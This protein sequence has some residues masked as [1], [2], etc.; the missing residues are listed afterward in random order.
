MKIRGVVLHARR[1]FVKEHFGEEAWQ[2]VLDA[3]PTEDQELLRGIVL[4]AQW[5]PFKLGER[6]D[7]AIVD[8]LGGG[9]VKV[10]EK[11][12]A[13]SAQRNLSKEHKS[14]LS[15]GDPQA[16]MKKTQLIYKFYYDS[17]YREYEETGSNSGVITTYEAETFSAPD[18]LTVIGWYKEALRMCGARDVEIV[19][20][21]CRA[22][23]GSCC[24]YRVTWEI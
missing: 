13:K 3:L 14:F 4:S 12:G 21:E 20:E 22:K 17:G 10:F 8:V 15:P 16:F 23:G 9:D 5:Y 19:E 18:C 24:R 7:K 1:E 2:K 6:I 11:I